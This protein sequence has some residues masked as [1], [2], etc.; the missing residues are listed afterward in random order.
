MSPQPPQT[1][2]SRTS[3]PQWG[4]KSTF[5][6]SVL[7]RFSSS[8]NEFQNPEGF[9]IKMLLWSIQSPDLREHRTTRSSLLLRFSS[10]RPCPQ[11][12]LSCISERR[13]SS[14]LFS[15]TTSQLAESIDLPFQLVTPLH[16]PSAE[17]Q[18]AS[19][20]QSTL[21]P[22]IDINGGR[23]FRLHRRDP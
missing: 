19:L 3:L 6:L 20:A 17:E 16:L 1:V 4:K 7:N 13:G 10:T 5:L 18:K 14:S 15:T 23:A 22:C 11:R 9:D 21:T 12:S 8:S 2:S